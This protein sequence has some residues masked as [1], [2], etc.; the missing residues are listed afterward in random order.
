M[1]AA[2]VCFSCEK[3]QN[4]FYK[5][6]KMSPFLGMKID[7]QYILDSSK[8]IINRLSWSIKIRKIYIAWVR[9]TDWF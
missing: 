1:L 7:N 3:G 4:L 2:K 9:L 6:C 5:R 8:K